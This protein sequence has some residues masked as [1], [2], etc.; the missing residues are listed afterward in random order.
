MA[1]TSVVPVAVRALPVEK[2][3]VIGKAISYYRI[4]EKLGGGG[5]SVVY[6]AAGTKLKRCRTK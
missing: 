3:S 5:M 4:T 1:P 6:K 2:F